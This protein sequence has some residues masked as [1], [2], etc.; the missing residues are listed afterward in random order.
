MSM[1]WGKGLA[2]TLAVF[3][4]LMAWFVVMALRNP[5]PLVTEQY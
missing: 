5:E 1:N 4:G 3:A 2:L